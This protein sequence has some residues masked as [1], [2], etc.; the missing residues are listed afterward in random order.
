MRLALSILP[1]RYAVCRFEP[2]AA[3]PDWADAPGFVSVTRTSEELSVVAAE[4]VVPDDVR[5]E[6]GWRVL[7]VAG[8][9]PFELTGVAAAV[10]SP[11]AA[12]KISVFPVATYDTDYILVKESDLT[13]A[14]GVLRASGHEIA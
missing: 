2:E 9:I 11:L 7:K 4:E 12:A 10:I 1:S 14:V 5:G 8:P 6:R 13:R 3:I